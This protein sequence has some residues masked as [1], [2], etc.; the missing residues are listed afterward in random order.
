MGKRSPRRAKRGRSS[1]PPRWLWMA[2]AGAAVL[3]VGA[4]VVLATRPRSDNAPQNTPQV[5]GSPRLA[6]DKTLIDEGYVKY[7][8]PVRT[9]FRLS[10]VGDQ[11]LKLLA[12]PQVR[13]VDG[14]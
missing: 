1:R 2:V 12:Q 3:A 5:L 4:L 9:T 7:D 6:V 8:V 14:C 13:L 10:N 11:P